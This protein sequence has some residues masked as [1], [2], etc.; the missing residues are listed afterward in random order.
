MANQNLIAD[1]QKLDALIASQQWAE[2]SPLAEQVM[3]CAPLTPGVL[4]RCIQ[5]LRAQNDWEA[6]MDLLMRSRNRYQLWP[7]GSDLL[8][9]QGMVELGKW[10]ESIPYLELAVAQDSSS[11][12]AHHFLG[13][14]MRHT[15]QLKVALTH[16]QQASEHLPEFPWAPFECAQLLLVQGQPKL[17]ILEMQEARRRSAE[18]NEVIEN[19]WQKLKPLVILEQV[20]QLIDAGQTTEAFSALR[21]AM[22]QDPDNSKLSERVLQLIS[23][24]GSDHG[25]AQQSGFDAAALLDQELTEIESLL[26]QLEGK[27]SS[28][29]STDDEVA[30][31]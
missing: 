19:E 29:K 1:L 7:H 15:G 5:V 14:A 9:G 24:D 21:Q 27:P 28:A 16:Q 31:V 11:G 13:K 26:D 20:D 18:T 8:M 17:A 6:L 4:E 25:P 2:A 12:W 3:S 22:L 10:S 30:F 23:A